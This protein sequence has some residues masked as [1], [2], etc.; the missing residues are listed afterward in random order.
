MELRDAI[1][2]RH[3]VRAYRPDRIPAKTVDELVELANLAPSAGNLQG[4][5]FVAVRDEPVREALDRA[6][7]DQEFVAQAP[8]V[9]VVCANLARTATKYGRRGR[10][11]YAI[12][13]AAA[14][15]ENLLL[16]AHGAGLGACW[17]GAFAEEAVRK[18][19]RLPADVRPVAIV[20][21]GY[22][23]EEP[24]PSSRLPLEEVL[25][26]AHW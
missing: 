3:S 2:T 15:T 17:V 12:Q 23:A 6:A 8:L 25:H 24:G 19:L 13:D 10:E 7:G 26:L 18:I 21:I 5:D 22:P 1:R 14:A 4:R 11:L 9:I 20:P 16:A